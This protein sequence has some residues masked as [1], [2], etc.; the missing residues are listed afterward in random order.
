MNRIFTAGLEGEIH[1]Y[2]IE[3]KDVCKNEDMVHTG[4]ILDLLPIPEMGYIASAG[5][6]KKIALWYMD[7]LKLKHVFSMGH[8]H[9]VHTLDWYADMK[10]ILSAGL[11]HD[12]YLWNP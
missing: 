3:L 7:T 6:D 11:D 4:D 5:M 12:I 1:A 9:G 2:N 8:Q 10:M